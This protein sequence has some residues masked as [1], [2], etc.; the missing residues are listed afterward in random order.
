MEVGSDTRRKTCLSTKDPKTLMLGIQK[1][2]RLEFIFQQDS[3]F[4]NKKKKNMS[5]TTEIKPVCLI[6]NND[7]KLTFVK[8]I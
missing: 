8:M 3:I 5:Y 1:F 2:I 4:I 6:E 7:A